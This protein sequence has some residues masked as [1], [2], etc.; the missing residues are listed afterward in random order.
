MICRHKDTSCV[1]KRLALFF[2]A[3]ASATF[4]GS[5]APLPAHASAECPR[6]KHCT[7]KSHDG[8]DGHE[9]VRTR[10]GNGSHNRNIVS[11][12]SP[13]STRGYQNTSNSTAGGATMV[14]N[15]L[16]RR[17]KVCNIHLKIIVIMPEKHE[18][19]EKARK[20]ASKKANTAPAEKAD[21]A[22]PDDAE[23]ASEEDDPCACTTR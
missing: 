3:G 12:K 13:E 10:D 17:A 16:C 5:I 4:I 7:T 1:K 6:T 19:A 14:Q 8:D 2:L 21:T 11:V 9:G 23:S 20:A 15:A 18:K 22:T